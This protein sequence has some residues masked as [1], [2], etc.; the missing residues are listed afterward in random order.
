MPLRESADF[1]LYL[2]R[3]HDDT[4]PVLAIALSTEK[5]SPHSIRRLEHEYSLA[6]ELDPAWA[7]KPLAITRQEERT[8]LILKDPGGEPLDRVLERNQRQPLDLTRFLRTAIGLAKTLGQ[9]HQHGLIHKDIKP[10]NVLV[11]D[12]GNAW[13]TGFGI[14]SQLPRERQSP[15][16]PGLIA[17]TLAYMAPEQTGRMNR[18]IDSRSDLYSL[19]ITFYEMLTGSLPFTPSD[20][21]ECVHCHIARQPAAPSERLGTVP[22]SVSAITMKLLSKTVEERYQTA[23]GVESDLRR[24]LS[25]W[26][27]QG[28]IDDFTL[29]AHDTPDR[30]MI[31][32]KLYGRDREVDTLL[33][34]FDRIVG[35]GRPE[36]VLVS[37]YSGIGKSEVVN[38]LHKPLVQPR[39]LFASGK[40]DQYKRDI[41]YATLAQAFQGPIRRLLSQNEEDLRKW[42]DALREALDPNGLLLVDLVPELKH[43]IGEQP[44]VP[45]LPPQEA[46]RRFQMVFRRFIGV[47]ARPEH[48]LAL[49][50]DDMQWLDVATLDLLQELLTQADVHHLLMIGA[51]R[52]NEVDAAHPLARRLEG[53]RKA[54]ASIKEIQLAPLSQENVAQLLIDA[55]QC[56]PERV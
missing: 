13:L 22:A 20:P 50:L 52:D 29:G 33:T 18:S 56:E 16:P 25:Q 55:L 37:G 30:L 42:Q 54:G 23:A 40:F 6:A 48:P 5:P 31:P 11:D 7:A 32:E 45:E 10:A 35:G 26:E 39:G 2:G 46:Q 3:K 34:A 36:L 12:T 28:C 1:T 14:A 41:P 38:E 24:C 19:G 15:E 53:I 44:P 43:I 17:G 8:I 47:F 49:F 27:S 4:S 51:Y 9:V 21:M